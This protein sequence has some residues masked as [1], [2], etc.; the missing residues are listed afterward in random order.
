VVGKHERA[1]LKELQ[2][3]KKQKIQEILDSQN[4]AIDA[5]MVCFFFYEAPLN[6]NA[7]LQLIYHYVISL[8]LI[9]WCI[10]HPHHGF[11]LLITEHERE[12]AIEVPV[13]ADRNICPLRKRKPI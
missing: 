9:I 3:L 1:R 12:R 13:A 4:A 7:H 11:E 2:K 10:L 6:T 5:D 8:T